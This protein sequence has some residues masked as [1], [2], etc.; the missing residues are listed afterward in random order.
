VVVE[1][2]DGEGIA[3]TLA[4]RFVVPGEPI[5]GTPARDVLVGGDGNDVLF[6]LAGND[7]LRGGAGDDILVGGPGND[8]LVGGPGANLFRIASRSS[9]D[10]DGDGQVDRVIDFDPSEG[11]RID[12]AGLLS[13]LGAGRDDIASF[14]DVAADPARE[15]VTIRVDLEGAGGAGAQGWQPIMQVLGTTDAAEV[16]ANTLI[17]L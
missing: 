4:V 2:I 14:L 9:V 12:L 13:E 10:A 16:Q 3:G 8:D 6:G 7:T 1:A 15:R 11:D 5:I 17:P